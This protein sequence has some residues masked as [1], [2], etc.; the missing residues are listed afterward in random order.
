MG[1]KVVDDFLDIVEEMSEQYPGIADRRKTGY[2]S[3][4][5]RGRIG[6]SL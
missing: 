5:R 2:R 3:P 1:D 4:S 6:V